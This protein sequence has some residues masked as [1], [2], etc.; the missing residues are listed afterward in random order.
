MLQEAKFDQQPIRDKFRAVQFSFYTQEEIE[1]MSVQKITSAVAF[2]HMNNPMPGGLHDKAL[3]VSPFDSLST[4][5][6]CGL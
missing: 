6:T 1:K 3:G 5:E 4:C 2:D